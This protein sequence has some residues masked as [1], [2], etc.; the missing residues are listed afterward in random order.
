MLISILL[1]SATLA[2]QLGLSAGL[3]HNGNDVFIRRFGPRVG[4]AWASGP[5][6]RVGASAAWYPSRGEGDWTPLS[7]TLSDDYH[8]LPDISRMTAQGR[9]ELWVLPFVHPIGTL[10]AYTGAYAGVGAVATREDLE[11]FHSE[12]DPAA[13]ATERQLHPTTTW[14]LCT[15]LGGEVV[16]GRLRFE[17]TTYIETVWGV[18]LEM[19]KNMLWALEVSVWLGS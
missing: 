2:G 8:F 13:L 19:K 14:G 10:N 16:R 11:A 1:C 6:L 4:A 15:E 12:D 9:A 5:H 3:E 18:A 7:H 17:R